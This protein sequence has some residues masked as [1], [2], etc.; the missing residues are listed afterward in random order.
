MVTHKLTIP[1]LKLLLLAI[2]SE[3]VKNESKKWGIYRGTWKVNGRP[4]SALE[5]WHV[6]IISDRVLPTQRM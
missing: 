2:K 3:H 1:E 6:V 4:I 5:S